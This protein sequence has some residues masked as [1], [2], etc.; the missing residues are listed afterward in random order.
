MGVQ[1]DC[2]YERDKSSPQGV[3]P[4]KN[5]KFECLEYMNN[6]VKLI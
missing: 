5:K 6:C 4:Q 1:Y 2:E 3:D